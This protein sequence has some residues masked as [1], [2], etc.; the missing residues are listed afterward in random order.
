MCESM[1]D[2]QS[3]IVKNR[4]KKRKKKKEE[5]EDRK[6]TTAA[7][8]NG[9]GLLALLGGHNKLPG[10]KPT[11]LYSRTYKPKQHMHAYLNTGLSHIR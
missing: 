2:I 1:V 3:A 9:H 4:D 5:E 11:A 6:E 7:N 8:Y 10:S